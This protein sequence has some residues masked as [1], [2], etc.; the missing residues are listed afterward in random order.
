MRPLAE[1]RAA[2]FIGGWMQVMAHVRLHHGDLIPGFDA[3]WHGQP[4]HRFHGEY[5]DALDELDGQLGHSGA[6]YSITSLNIQELLHKETPK[7]QKELSRAVAAHRHTQWKA[8]LDEKGRVA[9]ILAGASAEGRRPL[10]SEWLTST[11][12]T[13]MQTIPDTNYIIPI[14]PA[15]YITYCLFSESFR[16]A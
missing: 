3:G 5:Q 14:N 1:H 7:V 10:A 16:S 8:T 15:Q 11:P 4:V 12:S 13:R 9:G 6:T 2:A